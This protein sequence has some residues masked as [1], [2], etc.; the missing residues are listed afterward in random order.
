MP[1]SPASG[2]L[3]GYI[4][5]ATRGRIRGWACDQSAPGQP[6]RLR[7]IA[8]DVVLCEVVADRYRPD[9]AAAGIGDGRHAFDISI[10]G[11]LPPGGE[12]V[13]RVQRVSDGAALPERR[14]A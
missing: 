7:V 13:I 5:T 11:G 14:C 12:H 9:L 1:A 3:E 10:P 6:V 4:D 2:Q 8:N